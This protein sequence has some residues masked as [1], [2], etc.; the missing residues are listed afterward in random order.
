M[1]SFHQFILRCLVRNPLKPSPSDLNFFFL[2]LSDLNLRHQRIHVTVALIFSSLHLIYC[3]KWSTGRSTFWTLPQSNYLWISWR[4]IVNEPQW[5]LNESGHLWKQ[6]IDHPNF[7]QVELSEFKGF[8]VQL[9]WKYAVLCNSDKPMAC[10]E[11]GWK[12]VAVQWQSHSYSRKISLFHL[13]I[14]YFINLSK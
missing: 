1:F 3:S 4:S 11:G 7:K 6:Q 9:Q 2:F 12:Q 14:L 5:C 13:R 8:L 10:A